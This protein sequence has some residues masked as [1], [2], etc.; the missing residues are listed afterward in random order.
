VTLLDEFYPEA[1]FG[2]FSRVDGTIAFFS[3]VNA[4]LS[5]EFTALDVGCGRGEYA[6]DPVPF[7]RNLRILRGKCKRVIGID[8]DSNAS[9][10]PYVDSFEHIRSKHWPIED[11]SIDVCV[12]DHVVEHVEDVSGFL[13][14]CCR[15]LKNGGYLCIRTPNAFS[16]VAVAA[17]LISNRYHAKVLT[18]VQERRKPEDIFPTVYRCNTRARLKA[19]LTEAGFVDCIVYAHEAEPSYLNFSK[20]F[21]WFGV[22]HQRLSP[23]FI[24]PILFAFA[25]KVLAS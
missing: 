7:R 23:S 12:C 2:G 8:V 15:V 1:R 22:L 5:K 13:S 17:R 25:R 24:K 9:T 20:T 16:Y 14:E 11:N 19:A 4:L 10:N 3:R 18:K 6:E 21:Y